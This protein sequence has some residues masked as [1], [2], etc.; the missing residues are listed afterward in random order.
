[1]KKNKGSVIVLVV[2]TMIII[3]LLGTA[4]ID[5]SHIDFTMSN[6][7]V[8]EVKAYYIVEA[9]I[10]KALAKLRS[11][12]SLLN[13]LLNLIEG[14]SL[15]VI[16]KESFGGGNY[17][18]TGTS[19]AIA[20]TLKEKKISD[21]YIMVTLTAKGTYHNAKKTIKVQVKAD[22]ADSSQIPSTA[23]IFSNGST[24]VNNNV[25]INGDIFSRS[26]IN[27]LNNAV[28]N[29]SI[30]SG[31]GIIV[32]KATVTGTKTPHSPDSIPP[33]PE[34][35]LDQYKEGATVLSTSSLNIG[36]LTTGKYYI[37]DSV[38]SI[39]ISGTY[40]GK[41]T[42]ISKGQI[43]INGNVQAENSDYEN[44]A[45]TLITYNNIFVSN[46]YLAEGVLY[47]ATYQGTSGS[48]TIGNNAHVKG[49]ILAENITFGNN[50]I[51]D[52]SQELIKNFT[53]YAGGV[54]DYKRVSS[55]DVIYWK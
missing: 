8:N 39:T 38:S 9:G 36:T 17:F 50:A 14:Q 2:F 27:V 31:A 21:K 24:T 25:T 5:V 49:A 37:S 45:L 42:L 44:N 22:L 52:Y 19:E 41:I 54:A 53:G 10:N 46:N 23:A 26:Q 15:N 51:L 3:F 34:F 7:Q 43:N 20:L 30:T 32:N 13:S 55:L 35:S 12:A 47:A 16:D 28:V 18:G 1:M 33:Y 48:I 6:N 40:R 11:D 4:L 29:G